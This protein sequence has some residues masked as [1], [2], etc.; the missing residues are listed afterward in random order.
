MSSMTCVGLVLESAAKPSADL[1]YYAT[2]NPFIIKIVPSILILRSIGRSF[3]ILRGPLLL[4]GLHLSLGLR[5]WIL[6]DVVL[7]LI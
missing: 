6:N 7:I 5:I 2:R 3:L 4:D 1:S